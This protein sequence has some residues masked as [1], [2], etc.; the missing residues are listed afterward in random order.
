MLGFS[1]ACVSLNVAFIY[2][3]L[4]PAL[5]APVATSEA[6]HMAAWYTCRS[7]GGGGAAGPPGAHQPGVK[8]GAKL[9]R[10]AEP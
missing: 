3:L 9:G 1:A 10:A 8:K 4:N 6:Y 7:A 2:C 5:A